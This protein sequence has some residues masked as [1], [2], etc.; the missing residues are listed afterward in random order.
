M[1]KEFLLLGNIKNIYIYV[2]IF[3]FFQANEQVKRSDT[4]NS[5]SNDLKNN[6]F[7]A[8]IEMDNLKKYIEGRSKRKRKDAF[9]FYILSVIFILSRYD[10]TVESI[11]QRK[12]KDRIKESVK[13]G[14]DDFKRYEGSELNEEENGNRKFSRVSRD[15][16]QRYR[17]IIKS[18]VIYHYLRYNYFLYLYLEINSDAQETID[19][20]NSLYDA[21]EPLA[22]AQDDAEEYSIKLNDVRSIIEETM[23]TLFTYDG[24]YNDIN[25]TFSEAKNHCNEINAL[26]NNIN[27]SIIEGGKLTNETR[28]FILDFQNNVQVRIDG[29]D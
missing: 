18:I 21:T 2:S 16:C 9:Q 14:E 27:A 13:N 19:W 7:S 20:L 26:R 11:Q 24:L 5:K 15:S 6:I 22:I 29:I 1:L 3:Y 12:Q 25:Q 17:I 23:E 8:K 28:G 10:S 4:L